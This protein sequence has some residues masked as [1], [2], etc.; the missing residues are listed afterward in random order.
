MGEKI[1]RM[2]RGLK[3]RW[4]ETGENIGQIGSVN[5]ICIG[6]GIKMDWA[7][8][9]VGLAEKVWEMFGGK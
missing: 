5:T 9:N 3:H 4:V 7:G 8:V 1:V 6:G 2:G